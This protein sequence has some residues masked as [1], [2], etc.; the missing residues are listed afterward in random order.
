MI[1]PDDE[2]THD[3]RTLWL[4]EDVTQTPAVIFINPLGYS[5]ESPYVSSSVETVLGCTKEEWLASSWWEEHL[6][7]DDH[8]S[9]LAARQT[10]LLQ[11]FVVTDRVPHDDRR[12]PAR[13]DRGVRPSRHFRRR[14]LDA[15][16]PS[17]RHHDPQACR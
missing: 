3:E 17:R 14:A 16:G 11:N 10:L 12:R 8:D 4:R 9:V 15:A 1:Y 7:P 6:H 5:H 13:L 2:R